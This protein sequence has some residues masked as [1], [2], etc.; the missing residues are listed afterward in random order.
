MRK[1]RKMRQLEIPWPMGH[2]GARKGAGRKGSGG[3]S[4]ARVSHGARA[5]FGRTCV[6]HVTCRIGEGLPTLRDPETAKRVMDYLARS[7]VK[8]GFRIVEYSIQG[9]H[10]HMICEVDDHEALSR[11]MNGL[12]SGLAR[13]LNRYWG[14]RGKVFED[15]YHAEDL[16]T[17]KQCR[18]ALNYALHNAKKHGARSPRSGADPY[19]TAP[20]FPFTSSPP[21]RMDAK[22]AAHPRTWLLRTGWRKGG[23]IHAH[24]HPSIPTKPGSK[25]P[26]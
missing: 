6:L 10:I 16:P 11:A 13:T 22:P 17:P 26:Q 1:K 18:N 15:R 2:G 20:W 9:N 7:C 23:E 3:G 4:R 24:G 8:E 12:L 21:S 14:R 25:Q 19:S 5:C